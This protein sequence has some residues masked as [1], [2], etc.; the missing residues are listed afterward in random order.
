M[1]S[2]NKAD[3]KNEWKREDP[4]V[5][6][7]FN[8]NVEKE[9][10]VG[11]K[12]EH[13]KDVKNLEG[14]VSRQD[15]GNY[16]WL[17]YDHTNKFV[18]AGCLVNNAEKNYKHAYELRYWLGDA[19]KRFYGQPCKLTAGGNYKLS[20]ATSVNYSVELDAQAHVQAQFTH[21]I[22]SHWTIAAKQSYEQAKADKKPYQLG[23]EVTYNL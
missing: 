22:D 16:Q 14:G 9:Y 7:D 19:A 11:A 4:N 15:N 18:K 2:E 5:K 13:Q 12:V 1:S 6:F 10:N 3:D 8:V 21:K 23:F 17:G 20:S